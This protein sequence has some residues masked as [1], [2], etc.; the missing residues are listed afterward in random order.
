MGITDELS[1][2]QTFGGIA[3]R[4][5]GI[6][7]ARGQ[8]EQGF[9]AVQFAQNLLACGISPLQA[10][11]EIV[12]QTDDTV[13]LKRSGSRER[14]DYFRKLIS[15]TDVSDSAKLLQT[16]RECLQGNVSIGGSADILVAAVL[17]KNLSNIFCFD[18]K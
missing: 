14:Y 9:P 5:Y 11:C 18:V 15:D 1:S 10:L 3:F 4:K 13:L 16:N 8:A 12:G 7:G 17:Q 6:T 2:A